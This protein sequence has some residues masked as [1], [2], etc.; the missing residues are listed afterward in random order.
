MLFVFYA[1]C[2]TEQADCTGGNQVVGM[3]ADT[4][5]DTGL[6]FRDA[7]GNCQN[8]RRTLLYNLF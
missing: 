5:C 8:C 1:V 2:F 4:C 3:D 7:N 6:S